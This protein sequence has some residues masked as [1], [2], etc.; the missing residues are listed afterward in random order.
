MMSGILRWNSG[1]LYDR[2]TYGN[3]WSSTPHSYTDSRYLYFGST[4]VYPKGG[5]NK[6]LSF[7]L[8]CVAQQK[9]SLLFHP[10]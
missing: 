8:R 6:P 3:F 10:Q 4:S 5:S 2:G 9:S 7:A 1:N